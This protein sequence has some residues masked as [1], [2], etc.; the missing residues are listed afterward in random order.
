[1]GGIGGGATY[2]SGSTYEP[3]DYTQGD[4]SYGNTDYGDEDVPGAADGG[5]V[6]RFQSV[7]VNAEGEIF[8]RLKEI[9]LSFQKEGIGTEINVFFA[10]DESFDDLVDLG[11]NQGFASWN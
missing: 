7:H 5:V 10:G 3:V 2:G 4:T 9:N 1:M 6:F 8:G 11:M